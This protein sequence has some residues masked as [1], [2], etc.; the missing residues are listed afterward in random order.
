MLAFVLA[1]GKGTRLKPVT[2]KLPKALVEVGGMPLL[3]L[4]L[5]RLEAQGFQESLVNVHHHAGRLIDWIQNNPLNTMDVRVSDESSELLDT[6]GALKHAWEQ[7]KSHREVLVHNVDVISDTNLRK[8]ISRHRSTTA[9]VTLA[10]RERESSR[11]LLFDS[12]GYLVGWENTKTGERLWVNGEP[13]SYERYAFSGIHV[14]SP[15]LLMDF[16]EEDRFSIIP[17]YLALA[18]NSAVRA[19]V[20]NEDKWRDLGRPQDLREFD[21]Y[22]R[23]HEGSGWLQ[24][25]LDGWSPF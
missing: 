23:S 14:I 20:H 22:I 16:P 17:Y 1:A 13:S 24:K 18:R 12:K 7:L 5:K 6:G 11:Y 3:E 15:E 21:A 8:L 25:Y 10:V 4:V 9:A 2:D 19:W